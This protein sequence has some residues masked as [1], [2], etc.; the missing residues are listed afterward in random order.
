[1]VGLKIL[2]QF[3]SVWCWT[4]MENQG[5]GAIV[6]GIMAHLTQNRIGNKLVSVDK[7]YTM[8]SVCL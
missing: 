6:I 7:N 1:M 4:S 2:M 3:N 8:V 5:V